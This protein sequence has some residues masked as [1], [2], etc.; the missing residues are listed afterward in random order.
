MGRLGML[1]LG[2]EC[3]RIISRG[4]KS[5]CASLAAGIP[6][7]TLTDLV[8]LI[9]GNTGMKSSIV[10]ARGAL[11]KIR[12][13]HRW[14]LRV[15]PRF[16]VAKNPEVRTIPGV[17]GRVHRFDTMIFDESPESIAAYNRIGKSAWSL[18]ENGLALANRSPDEI[19]ELLDFGCG[20]GRVTRAIVQKISAKKISVFDADPNAALFCANEFKVRPLKFTKRSGWN[21]DS[22]PFG[23]YD[24]IWAGSVFTHLSKGFTEET[25]S[26]I[27][28]LLNPNG[29]LIFTTH[30]EKTFWRLQE[31]QYGN[32][33]QSL[34]PKI[35]DDFNEG[36]FCFIPY[37]REEIEILPFRFVRAKDF[38]MSWMS[39]LFVNT[40]LEDVSSGRLTQ[41][42]FE[43]I[44]WDGHQDVHCY[45]KTSS[46]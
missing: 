41:L 35:M 14:Y 18:I 1:S 2:C 6:E 36:G 27:D 32:R 5:C 37:D 24:V 30:G 45:K 10:F 19:E 15:R 43:P 4:D 25:L 33:L 23:N 11:K 31:G 20:Y 42:C 21:Y 38:G 7:E 13:F 3:A 28:R 39:S 12:P 8:V 40:L 17:F 29:L 16:P 9:E 26:L 34:A 22:V 44:G 46:N